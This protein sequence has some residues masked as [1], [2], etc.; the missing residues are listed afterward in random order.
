MLGART[1]ERVPSSFYLT[2]FILSVRCNTLVLTTKGD[3]RQL[4]LRFVTEFFLA[5]LQGADKTKRS[6]WIEVFLA[7]ETADS[8]S[9]GRC[10]V[11]VQSYT[12]VNRTAL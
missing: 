3:G 10:V 12:S 7:I 8:L 1:T 5:I 11:L 6:K 2:T 9:A 4:T